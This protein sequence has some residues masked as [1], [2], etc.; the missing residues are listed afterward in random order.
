MD[1]R[2]REARRRGG[3]EADS[4]PPPP[5]PSPALGGPAAANVVRAAPRQGLAR[6]LRRGRGRAPRP[7]D[8]AVSRRPAHERLPRR[9]TSRGLAR[10]PSGS[11]TSTTRS[12]PSSRRARDQSAPIV[13]YCSGGDCEDSHML[14]EK[15]YIVGFDNVLVYKDGYPDWVKRGLPVT[16][17]ARA[18]SGGPLLALADGPRP[19]RSGG[20]LRR[21]GIR[22]DRGSAGL[23]PRDPQLRS[24][25]RACAVNAMA[26]VLPWLEVVAGVALFLGIARRSAARIL[27]DPACSSSSWPSSIN[28][29]RGRPVD[30]GCFGTVKVQKTDAERLN[31]MKLAILRDVGLLLLAGQILHATRREERPLGLRGR[32]VRGAG[33]R[34]PPGARAREPR[35]ARGAPPLRPG[36]P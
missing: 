8:R 20:L 5:A 36:R 12:R 29:A 19:V 28:L 11:P 31:D 14:S 33:R 26:L 32:R 27:G 23:R 16:K 9:A 2:V 13:V 25:C 18:V 22:Q 34:A 6:D 4:A 30:C 15:L 3:R 35:T 10:S 17:G 21:R 7:Q 24:A 1:R